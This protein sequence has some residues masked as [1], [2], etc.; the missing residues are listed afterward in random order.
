VRAAF[1]DNFKKWCYVMAENAKATLMDRKPK[2]SA[3]PPLT[4]LT[5]K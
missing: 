1:V 4:E 3:L 2:A 5:V